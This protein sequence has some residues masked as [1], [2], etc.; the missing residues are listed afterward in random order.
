MGGLIADA[1]AHQM[2][3]DVGFVNSGSIRAG[4]DV[5]VSAVTGDTGEITM[6][7]LVAV[8]AG[9]CWCWLYKTITTFL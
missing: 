1:L 2:D 4:L 9:I 5:D 8:S 7:K 3:V 6:G